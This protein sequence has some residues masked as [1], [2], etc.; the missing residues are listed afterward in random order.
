LTGDIH[1][2]WAAE[3]P[4][5]ASVNG[6]TPVGVEFVTPSVTSDG[7][8]EI[9][10]PFLGNPAPEVAVGATRQVTGAVQVGNPWVKYLD[11]I[12]H[13]FMVI[14]VTPDRV[15]ADF[16][17]TPVPTTAVPDPRTHPALV[18]TYTRSFQ[19]LASSRAVTSATG[20]VGARS[21]VPA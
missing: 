16:H 8:Y 5:G 17:H 3:L 20:P 10:R 7:F 12:S 11:G 6:Y 15:Q 19:T 9:V 13:G 2:S 18:P 21:D 4:V 14:D 1:S